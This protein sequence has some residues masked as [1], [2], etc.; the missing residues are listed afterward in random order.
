M[1]EAYYYIDG[2]II[3]VCYYE[4]AGRL[5]MKTPGSDEIIRTE[6]DKEERERLLKELRGESDYGKS[7]SIL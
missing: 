4:R 6:P 1:R 3:R 2:E 7:A 5:V